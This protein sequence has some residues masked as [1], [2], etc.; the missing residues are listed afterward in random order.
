MKTEFIDGK[1]VVK[2]E[3]E[4]ELMQ[5]DYFGF[6]ELKATI[7]VIQGDGAVLTVEFAGPPPTPA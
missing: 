2:G 6:G 7:A 3:N 1:L 4:T 5:L